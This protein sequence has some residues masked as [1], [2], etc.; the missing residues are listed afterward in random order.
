M[1]RCSVS[2]ICLCLCL[3]ILPVPAA[4]PPRAI[5]I[6]LTRLI[7]QLG[8]DRAEV[9][10]RATRQLEELDSVPPELRVATTSRDP[11]VR[12]RARWIVQSIER[13]AGRLT[14][15]EAIALAKSGEVDQAIE[16]VVRWAE[17]DPL[18]DGPQALHHLATRLVDAVEDRFAK[19]HLES[20]LESTT[21]VLKLRGP[22]IEEGPVDLRAA[23]RALIYK[24]DKRAPGRFLLR[25]RGVTIQGPGH[26]MIVSSGPVKVAGEYPRSSCLVLSCG[27]VTVEDRSEHLIIL[28]DGNVQVRGIG[29]RCSLIVARGNV[30]LPSNVDGCAVFAGGTITQARPASRPAGCLLRPNDMSGP[31]VIKFFDPAKAGIEVLAAKEGVK[32]KKVHKG[33]PFAR[34]LREGDV[35]TAIGSARVDSPEGFRRVLRAAL[36]EGTRFITLALRREDRPVEVRLRIRR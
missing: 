15:Q 26:G 25:G 28:S 4:A 16:R 21:H 14:L 9:R 10:A 13:G 19:L 12:R 36:A 33:K 2:A 3:V 7:E 32:V 11:E 24:N 34:A 31:G 6:S 8:S 35:V 1:S 20:T 17:H 27:S 29:L 30:T 23:P 18:R 5:G 22:G